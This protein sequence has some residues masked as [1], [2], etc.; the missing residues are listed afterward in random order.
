MAIDV[1]TETL[2]TM[3]QAK[4]AFPG[5][6]VGMASLTRWRVDGVRGVKLET[7]LVGGLR[8]TSKEAIQRFI[9]AQNSSEEAD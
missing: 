3:T 4:T 7:L 8:Y 6:T 5:R 9:E 2:I 1:K